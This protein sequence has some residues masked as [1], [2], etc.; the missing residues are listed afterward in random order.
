MAH[1]K[2]LFEPIQV[3]NLELKN[4]IK[5]PA[6]AV[7]PPESEDVIINR[8]KAFYIERAKGGVAII[9]VSCTATRL[10]QD[11]MLG[12]YDD[13]FIKGL[14]E[15]T[16][17]VHTHDAKMYAQMGVGYSW[18]F[19]DGPVELV[20]PSGVSLSGRPGTPFRMGG[21]WDKTF[22]RELSADEIHRIAEDYGDGARRAREAGFDAVEVI[23]SVGYIIAQFLSPLTNKR[24]DEYGGSLGNRMRLFLEIIESMKKKA[25]TDFTYTCRLSGSDLLK[26]GYTLNDTAGMA[27]ILEKAG[28][29]EIDVMSGWHNAQVPIIQTDVPQ[30]NWSYM[31][32]TVKKAVNIPVAA[33]TQIQ[34]V[35]VAERVIQEGESDMVY[36]ARALLADPEL[37]NKAKE[38]R[39]ADIRPCMNC[40][41]CIEAS[42]APPVY[43]S[44]NARLSREHEYP[45]ELPASIRKRVLVVGGGPSGIEAA[46]IASIRGHQVTLCEQGPRLGGSLLLAAIT[47]KRIGNVVKYLDRQLRKLPVELKFYT[48]VTPAL[49]RKINPDVVVLAVGG[50]STVPEVPGSN[51]VNVLDHRDMKELITGRGTGKGGIGH[52]FLSALGALFVRFF[53][54][55]SLVRWM[56]KFNFPFK[57][58]VAIIGGGFAG[59]ELGITLVERGKKVSIIEGSKRIGHDVGLVHRWVWLKQLRDA[60]SRLETEARV[61]GITD[62]GVEIG[63]GDSIEFIEADTIVVAGGL[64]PN[65][66]LSEDFSEKGYIV[67]PIGDCAGPGKLLEATAHGFLLGHQI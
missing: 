15:L 11:P 13:G 21:P 4:R 51:N 59:C 30:G 43:C 58:R 8:L 25:G 47:N 10:I 50:A 28:I 1:L 48:E 14:R 57:K 20:S 23:A 24:T 41:R 52:R 55:P 3:G 34:D 12:L 40:C 37:P 64:K 17:A 44:V 63:K 29:H 42:D 35:L 33:G 62:K 36:M 61:L 22:P 39:L 26:G 54:E 32:K 27:Q 45:V 60:G 18:A 2:R 7:V 67:Y 65:T 38:G 31:A 46:R 56:L 16:D 19:G 5:M 53:Y 9:G 6:M 49:V 66:E